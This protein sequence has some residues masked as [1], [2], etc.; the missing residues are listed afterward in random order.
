LFFNQNVQ[1]NL[2]LIYEK[3]S[4]SD[5]MERCLIKDIYDTELELAEKN[6]LKDTVINIETSL[7]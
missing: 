6:L 1:Q 5:W 7:I 4:A 3:E 2:D